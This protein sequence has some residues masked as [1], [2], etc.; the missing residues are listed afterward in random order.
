MDAS[1]TS[2]AYIRIT[3]DVISKSRND[4]VFTGELDESVLTELHSIWR[5]K[6]IQAGVIRGTIETSSP[7]IQN[8]NPLHGYAQNK[9]GIDS[10]PQFPSTELSMSI[11][12]EG[13]GLY[14]PQQDGASD[15]IKP[16]AFAPHDDDDESLNEDDDYE[17]DDINDDEDIPHLIMC[18]FDYVK[19]RKNKWECKLKAGVMQ[20]NEK[21]ILFSET[22]GDFTF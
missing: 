13:E 20:I 21:N 9:S 2:D 12:N 22:K 18:Q 15:D 6:M 16:S 4:L 3:N 19:K 17:E 5:R 11:K 14:I 7:P 10:D 8:P 1:N